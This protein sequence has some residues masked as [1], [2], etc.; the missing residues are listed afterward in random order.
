MRHADSGFWPFFGLSREP[1]GS[2]NVAGQRPEPYTYLMMACIHSLMR[3]TVIS[4]KALEL[5][6]EQ[7][8]S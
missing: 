8:I 1:E 5:L 2:Y 7:R 3:D 6:Q 4:P